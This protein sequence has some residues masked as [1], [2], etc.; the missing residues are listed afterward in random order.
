MGGQPSRSKPA[1]GL[2]IQRV[3]IDDQTPAP[4]ADSTVKG[5]DKSIVLLLSGDQLTRDNVCDIFQ[6]LI[7]ERGQLE[8]ELSEGGGGNVKKTKK[9]KEK[10]KQDIESCIKYLGEDLVFVLK[11]VERRDE[12]LSLDREAFEE[13]VKSDLLVVPDESY[14][15][16]TVGAWAE[17]RANED[18][19]RDRKQHGTTTDS[20]KQG[21]GTCPPHREGITG[22]LTREC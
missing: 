16:L 4:A 9:K 21:N 6:K 19:M 15:L 7:R 22:L 12:L 5:A 14:V 2:T 3:G 18:E 13:I 1:S 20:E 17:R 11:D 10:V 8:R